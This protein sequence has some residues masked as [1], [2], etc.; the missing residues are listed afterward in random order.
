MAERAMRRRDVTL[1]E[2]ARR[3]LAAA[4]ERGWPGG[5]A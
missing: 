5:G 1:S 2:D 3:Q 4:H